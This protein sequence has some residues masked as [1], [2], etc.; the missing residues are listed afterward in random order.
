MTV[1]GSVY[2]SWYYGCR[3]ASCVLHPP[4]RLC[5]RSSAY[6]LRRFGHAPPIAA[7]LADELP[8]PNPPPALLAGR[9]AAARTVCKKSSASFIGLALH[10]PL[11]ELGELAA[12]LRLPSYLTSVPPS[13]LRQADYRAA[14]SNPATPPSPSPEL[15]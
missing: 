3:K 6:C 4:T 9:S 1:S 11:G 2:D 8:S 14:L 5:P 10:E 13:F 7:D 12:D 15:L